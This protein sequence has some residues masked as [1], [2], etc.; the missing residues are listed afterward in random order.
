MSSCSSSGQ[1]GRR[2]LS[3]CSP[4][5]ELSGHPQRPSEA[6]ARGLIRYS[7]LFGVALVATDLASLTF[8][9]LPEF[10]LVS[11]RVHD[12]AELSE[13]GVVGLLEHVA[14]FLPKRLE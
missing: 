2:L 11:L 10:D 5:L 3:Q 4:T 13:I 14:A 1:L 8:G 9:R 6:K 12:P 7:E